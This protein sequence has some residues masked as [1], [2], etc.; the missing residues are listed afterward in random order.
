MKKWIIICAIVCTAPVLGYHGKHTKS[1][2]ILLNQSPEV[3]V[4]LLQHEPTA[5]IEAKGKFQV[6]NYTTGESLSSSKGRKCF[7]MHAFPEGLRWGEEYPDC[8][9]L[10]LKA[11]TEDSSLF[12]NGVQYRGNLY[13]VRE[14][15]QRLTVIN[16]ID[17]EEYLRCVLSLSNVPQKKESLA[18]WVILQRT[19]MHRMVKNRYKQPYDVVASEVNYLGYGVV[20]KFN[21]VDQAVDN[22]RYMI[23][24][25]DVRMTDFAIEEL[26]H[27][28]K[29][30]INAK[31]IL[32]KFQPQLEL[33][34]TTPIPGKIIR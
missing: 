21:G 20:Q 27:Y 9:V 11:Q 32:H 3:R 14:K 33:S 26:D 28:A 17:L 23:C 1:K 2:E 13:I 7:T 34:L 18:A 29:E 12:V 31:E 25:R 5:L 19:A 15:D 24:D 8:T 16:E 30:G 22:T 4:L 10:L 6:L